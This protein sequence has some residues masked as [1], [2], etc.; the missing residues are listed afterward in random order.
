VQW[1]WKAILPVLNKSITHTQIAVL[2]IWLSLTIAAFAY[3]IDNKLV[4]FNADN[5]LSYLDHQQLSSSLSQYNEPSDNNTILHFSQPNCQCQ[6]FSEAH[7]SD[8]NSLAKAN[9]FKV[10]NITIKDQTLLPATPSVA[11]VNKHGEVVYFGPYGEGIACS[12]TSG[13]A[14]TMLNN[15][16]KGYAANLIIKDAKGCYCKT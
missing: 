12:Q 5:K 11:I 9:N 4:D 15:F 10:K 8:M 3:F 14:Q 6:S 1:I 7:I 16:I 2:V 13:F